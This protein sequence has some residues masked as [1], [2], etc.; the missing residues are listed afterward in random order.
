MWAEGRASRRLLLNSRFV[1]PVG[2]C[3]TILAA[4][5]QKGQVCVCVC[6]HVYV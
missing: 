1:S 2:D 4:K 5:Q 3:M 6:V